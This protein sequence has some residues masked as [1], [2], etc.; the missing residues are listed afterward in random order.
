MGV[1]CM[2]VRDTVSTG[3]QVIED[4]W[5]WYAQ[6]VHGNV[7]YFGEDT[8][9]FENGKVVSTEGTWEGGVGGA[10]PG[11]VMLA[12]PQVG[13]TY[14]QEY[15]KG[16]AEDMA[17]VLDLSTN[18]T[19]P[20]GS[21]GHAVQTK[22]WTP[23]QPKVLENKYYVAGIGCVLEVT[24]KGGTDRVELVEYVPGGSPAA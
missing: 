24:V 12:D 14:H 17:Q 9:E 5:D 21:Y 15:L 20:A 19:V 1:T 22:E 7:W 11:I 8:K 18:A 3:G 23:L 4:T 13:L 10:R 6:D 16:V 2:V